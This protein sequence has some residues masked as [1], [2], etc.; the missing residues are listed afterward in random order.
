MA[1][2]LTVVSDSEKARKDLAALRAS[3]NS[4]RSVAENF[5][6]NPFSGK[7]VTDSKA[8]NKALAQLDDTSKKVSVNFKSIGSA[9][10]AASNPIKNIS[11]NYATASQSAAQMAT[12][13]KS[14]SLSIDAS[15]KS[16]ERFSGVAQQLTGQLKSMALSAAAFAGG[17]ASISGSIRVSD[18]LTQLESKL[19]LATS[20][21]QEFNAALLHTRD[22][23]LST[24]VG[25]T[26]ITDLYA[27][28]SK[29]TEGFQRSQQDVAEVTK[30]V[31]KSLAASGA[32][33][34]NSQAAVLQLGQAL[35]SGIL[36]GD[37]LNSIMENA[38]ALASAIAAGLGKT[39][40][41]LRTLGSEGKL[42][43]RD[44]FRAILSQTSAIDANFKKAG[45]TFSQSFENMSNSGLL[46][47]SSLG[48]IFSGGSA[49]GGSG[50]AGI[51]KTIPDLINGIALSIAKFADD[52]GYYVLH[53]KTEVIL[54]I[55]EMKTYLNAPLD[56]RFSIKKLGLSDIF[57]DLSGIKAFFEP[58]I[59]S[60]KRSFSLITRDAFKPKSM[61]T[62]LNEDN[63]SPTGPTLDINS[64]LGVI[65]TILPLL[66]AGIAALTILPTKLA[67]AVKVGVL[68]SAVTAAGAHASA[69][70]PKNNSS[71]MLSSTLPVAIASAVYGAIRIATANIPTGIMLAIT[72]VAEKIG[73]S[74]L[75][76]FTPVLSIILN[77]TFGLI[78]LMSGAII[79]VGYLLGKLDKS[80]MTNGMPGGNNL[81]DSEISKSMD[82]VF[83]TMGDLL[84]QFARIA[85]FSVRTA[86]A[87]SGGM[88]VVIRDALAKVIE[89]L[90]RTFPTFG[91]AVTKFRLAVGLGDYAAQGGTGPRKDE[92]N[93][94]LLHD[95]LNTL[96]P[97]KYQIPVIGATAAAVAGVAALV[98]TG[99][100]RDILLRA[101]GLTA[102]YILSNDVE[103]REIRR[104]QGHLLSN[105][106]DVVKKV[107]DA[108][109]GTGI[110]GE[111]GFSGMLRVLSAIGKAMLLFSAG[112]DLIMKGLGSAL[113]A[114]TTFAQ[115]LA[116]AGQSK[117]AS[118]AY[119][120]R[121][122]ELEGLTE[123]GKTL[124]EQQKEAVNNLSA[125][126]MPQ[127]SMAGTSAA[128]QAAVSSFKSM[129]NNAATASAIASGKASVNNAS[130]PASFDTLANAAKYATTRMNDYSN[131]TAKGV[132]KLKENVEALR[133]H[134]EALKAKVTETGR[135]FKEGVTNTAAG[136]G[137]IFGTLGGFNI[138]KQI[139]DGMAGASDW[140]KIGVTMGTALAGQALGAFAGEAFSVILFKAFSVV[141]A[142]LASPIFLAVAAFAAIFGV[143]ANWGWF[144]KQFPKWQALALGWFDSLVSLGT[145]WAEQLKD[146]F[147]KDS[148]TMGQ[149][150][151]NVTAQQTIVDAIN[152]G[153]MGPATVAILREQL[154]V[155]RADHA[156]LEKKFA[157]ETGWVQA[158]Y[159]GSAVR[160]DANATPVL[161]RMAQGVIGA[162][163]VVSPKAIAAIVAP[164]L[165]SVAP[166]SALRPNEA[167]FLSK[168]AESFERIGKELGVDSKIIAAQFAN[169]TAYGRGI[170]GLNN[171]GNIKATKGQSGTLA[172]DTIEGS[173]DAYRNYPDI[174]AFEKDFV[175]NVKRNWPG[176]I[177]AGS[178]VSK[179]NAGMKFGQDRGYA[180]DAN[181]GNAI[182]SIYN[183]FAGSTTKDATIKSPNADFNFKDEISKYAN[184]IA[185]ML[186]EGLRD[187]IKNGFGSKA[188]GN[189]LG[190]SSAVFAK[191]L[192][193]ILDTKY[194]KEQVNALDTDAVSASIL[195]FTAAVNAA[196]KN[197][198]PSEL[199]SIKLN[200]QLLAI[201]TN[202]AD[203]IEKA[204]PKE[205][206]KIAVAGFDA[207]NNVVQRL[208]G[209]LS[210]LDFSKLSSTDM[211]RLSTLIEDEVRLSKEA[212]TATGTMKIYLQR[213]GDETRETIRNIIE[214]VKPI[215][216][217][218]KKGNSSEGQIAGDTFA[219]QFQTSMT[220]GFSDYLKGKATF[221]SFGQMLFDNFTN[222]VVDAFSKGFVDKLFKGLKLDSLFSDAIAGIFDLGTASADT[223]IKSAAETFSNAVDRFAGAPQVSAKEAFRKSELLA[224][225]GSASISL[226]TG[227]E[228][229]AMAEKFG[230][231]PLGEQ[232][233]MLADQ[234]AGFGDV[235][236]A[237]KGGTKSVVAGLGSLGGLLS[238]PLNSMLPML[239]MGSSGGGLM[240]MLGG[241]GKGVS[242]ALSGAGDWLSGLLSFDVGGVIPGGFGQ[243]I[244]IMAHGGE[245][246]LN[247][248]Q[249]QALLT[250]GG[251]SG[252]S[253]SSSTQ[254]FNIN[255]TGD[256]SRQTRTE[257]QQMIPQ[258]ATGV[259]MHNYENGRR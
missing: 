216:S 233:K 95:T 133:V 182:A 181:A 138:G 13:S 80:F 17:F 215:P 22:A 10:A 134:S 89:S 253:D 129:Q 217:K 79:G 24:R 34:E 154:A 176:A 110:F 251:A 254:V 203:T 161:S 186:P 240:G 150:D 39:T 204:A 85:A 114:P 146:S 30:N 185:E 125:A 92:A 12:H 27:K 145:K 241:I 143:Y 157:E 93:R 101:V 183:K 111:S 164:I 179:Y 51:K 42:V 198:T 248:R 230:L 155:M 48:K 40:G 131:A 96:V 46:L 8:A 87:K 115:N 243:P 223:V 153:A 135:A 255:V 102:G 49:G 9:A 132:E 236:A 211:K 29:S 219:A 229:M 173:N 60:L 32:S 88:L 62:S 82:S 177:G 224:Q 74:R 136:I 37:E 75:A 196:Y 237:T 55:S 59:D 170:P 86:Y 52:L 144:E 226:A 7:A 70:M 128:M 225:G 109:F 168:Y 188:K 31:A 221:A 64:K 202:V 159:K 69:A 184:V 152:K 50:V 72:T 73:L 195:E 208:G 91:A 107:T 169:E 16:A 23:A 162:P 218:N 197:G 81:T 56:M 246:M 68:L 2:Q 124:K 228:Q 4:I 247:P 121:N 78:S 235:T 231:D 58:A 3:I 220:S 214:S 242:G 189:P 163:P 213:Y 258:I 104:V 165:K 99:G 126:K 28:I 116:T 67:A 6:F 20:S 1:I 194:T 192:N 26:A 19:K 38:P 61:Q 239:S 158:F 108:I 5:S 167:Q 178:D 127:P 21:Q 53:I 84:K 206:A 171:L 160:Q 130:T 190:E 11:A 120:K 137:G 156:V 113:T 35:G 97:E 41:Q 151:A 122:R 212:A 76:A 36:R 54:A 18:T 63:S 123:L 201:K 205:D 105:T 200:K 244:P 191:N 65:T 141:G 172:F 199:T 15:S 148:I 45:V 57:P 33:A 210:E 140:E 44:V 147:T 245:V 14:A 207:M 249:Q 238:A 100:F 149:I 71:E 103:T 257:I 106:L 66:V 142:V 250:S 187:A 43:S 209:T 234:E 252:R 222:G 98:T 259:N 47:A 94:P 193:S 256:I 77:K 180:T 119:T 112:R 25:I 174:T 83:A 117:Y 175:G 139:A 166:T 90:S 232:A 227:N 118:M